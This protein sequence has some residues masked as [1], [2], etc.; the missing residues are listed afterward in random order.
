MKKGLRFLCST[1]LA[2]SSLI[3]FGQLPGTKPIA[4]IPEEVHQLFIDDQN[5]R[6]GGGPVATYGKDSDSRDAIRREQVRILLAAGKI[7]TARDFH[8]AAYIFQHGQ[9]ASD[10]LLAHILA[11]EGVIKGDATSRW[12]SAATL[13]R[14]LQ[15]VGQKQ[16]FGT[17]YITKS[18][19]D[20]AHSSASGLT[21]LKTTST[22]EPYDKGLMPDPLRVDFCVPTIAQQ[23]V[24]LKEFQ[25]GRD[26]SVILPPGCTR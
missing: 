11:V 25:A 7:Q 24:T 10:Y 3:A 16:V 6:D 21:S 18:V 20:S 22:Q 19:Q 26:P 15:A 17:Q 1:A 12:I 13:D 14:Y 23:E 4:T 8:D 5:E 2:S 9:N